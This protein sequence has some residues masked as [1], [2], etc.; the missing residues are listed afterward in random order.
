MNS[1]SSNFFSAIAD[2]EFEYQCYN[3]SEKGEV[4]TLDK[5]S[6]ILKKANKK[7]LGKSIFDRYDDQVYKYS[8]IAISHIFEQPFYI[9]KY[10]VSIA[11][12][13]KLYS[14]FKRTKD[15]SQIINFLKDGGSLKAT[16]L[17]K[18]YNFDCKK[19]ESYK[20]LILEVEKLVE[21]F[22]QL[23]NKK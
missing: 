1:F 3:S 16:Q 2:A 11:V 18:K 5:I 19:E 22:E 17:F 12:S 20:D 7:V 23:L 15:A 10:A 9:Y 21:N 8:W 4:L 6:E 13:F 14:E